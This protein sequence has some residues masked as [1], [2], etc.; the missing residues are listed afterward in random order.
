VISIIIPVYNSKEYLKQCIDS[1]LEQTIRDIEVILVDDASTDGSSGVCD[2]IAG[3]DRRVRVIHHSCNMGLSASRYDGYS[4][5]RGEWIGFVDND[6]YITPWLY[7]MLLENINGADICCASGKDVS[8]ERFNTQ[9][10]KNEIRSACEIRSLTGLKS[11]EI[12]E[13]HDK[14]FGLIGCTWGKMYRRQIVDRA[15]SETL[16]YRES[17]PWLFFEDL[18]FV[19]ISFCKAKN[20]VFCLA[21]GYLH[22]SA[23]ESLSRLRVMKPYHYETA[24]AGDILL[25]YFKENNMQKLYNMYLEGYLANLQSIWYRIDHFEKDAKKKDAGMSDIRTVYRKYYR[26]YKKLHMRNATSV[27][28]SLFCNAYALWEIIVGKGY[29]ARKYTKT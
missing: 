2:C 13:M 25:C 18:I 29:F 10:V 22:R 7:E 9:I 14:K 24:L 23:P 6:D 19:P 8:N 15:L 16:K 11:A 4:A 12:N 3:Y 28:I 20:I 27:T 26:D 17:I 5:S 21:E 1:V